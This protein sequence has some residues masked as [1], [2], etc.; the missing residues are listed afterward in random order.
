MHQQV[1]WIIAPTAVLGFAFGNIMPFVEGGPAFGHVQ[2]S[3]SVGAAKMPNFLTASR[4]DTDS[5][6]VVGGG[7]AY[8]SG[9]WIF[10]IKY[11]YFNF[12]DHNVGKS[13]DTGLTVNKVPFIIDATAKNHETYETIKASM[14]YQLGGSG[15]VPLK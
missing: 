10:D 5:G 3:V 14:S 15:Y 1:D 13:I 9:S 4:E 2:E 7:I 6:Y 8:K 11:D 12:G